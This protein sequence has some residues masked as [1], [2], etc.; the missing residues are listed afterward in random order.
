MTTQTELAIMINHE[1]DECAG[2]FQLYP[3][4]EESEP[5]ELKAMFEYGPGSEYETRDDAR[6]AAEN[7]AQRVAGRIGGQWFTNER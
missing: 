7:E 3:A 1:G 5:D 2:F 6:Q 4:N